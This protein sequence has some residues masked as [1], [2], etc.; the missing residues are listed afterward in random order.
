MNSNPKSINKNT[1]RGGLVLTRH[2]GKTLKIGEDIFVTFLGYDTHYGARLR[3]QAPQD[4]DISRI[5]Q[6]E[7]NSQN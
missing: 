4:Y 1:S 5:T 7:N 2:S 3:I 6:I